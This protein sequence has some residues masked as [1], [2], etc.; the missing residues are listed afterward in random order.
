MAEIRYRDAEGCE[1]E[2]LLA[3]DTVWVQRLDA[4]GG[5]G[6]WMMAGPGDQPESRG[7]LRA[8]A[9]LHTATL[10]QL[11]TDRRAEDSDILPSDDGNRR[12]WWGDS[13][14]LDGEPDHPLGSRLWMLARGRLNEQTRRLAE[15]YAI[16]ALDVLRTQGAVARTDVTATIDRTRDA[17]LIEVVHFGIDGSRVYQQQFGVVWTQAGR[18]AP[19]NFGEQGLV[20]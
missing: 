12:G 18:N 14:R 2:P 1:P 20:A 5:Y 7:G 10:L 9:A 4:A 13:I 3:W 6:D 11:F 15:D 19:M 8:E 16:E 17:I